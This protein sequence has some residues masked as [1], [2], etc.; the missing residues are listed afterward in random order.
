MTNSIL[1]EEPKPVPSLSQVPHPGIE[2]SALGH[3][4]SDGAL[5]ASSEAE[6][7]ILLAEDSPTNQ[8][9]AVM[10]L[11]QAGH[12]VEVV[13]NGR[14]A[15]QAME[16]EDFDLVLMDVFMPEM[17]GLEATQLIRQGQSRTERRV[18]ILA[19]TATDTQE[20]RE[21]CLEAGMDGFMSKPVTAEELVMVIGPLLTRT[22]GARTRERQ[23]AKKAQSA[24]TV[25]LN[26]ALEVVDGDIELLRD[27]VEMFLQE[28]PAQIE[29]LREALAQQDAPGVE[30]AAHRLKGILGNVGGIAA[31]H[32][33][34][35][36][37][38]M[39]EEGELDGG[40]I[41]LQELEGE[42]ARV[43]AFFSKPGWEQ[44]VLGCEGEQ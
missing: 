3:R 15:V 21:K 14:K 17:D 30:S 24:Q 20:H 25:D 8:L 31:R 10:N 29:T 16:E 12:I 42:I 32:P 5:S 41:A 13:D 4:H 36:L 33:A 44:G 35:Y 37:E 9:I 39:G 19:M 7:H 22:E 34:H 18:T 26:A 43:A 27:V 6:L 23:A 1:D 40:E 2:E 38:T 28:Y 11:E